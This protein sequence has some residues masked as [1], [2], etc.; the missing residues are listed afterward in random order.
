M[1]RLW[2]VTKGEFGSSLGFDKESNDTN[3]LGLIK[4]GE[5]PEEQMNVCL[6]ARK[7]TIYV[8]AGECQSLSEAVALSYWPI[9][10]NTGRSPPNQ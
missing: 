10:Q 4:A 6:F 2:V 8:L 7:R 1:N 9:N 3:R 5:S